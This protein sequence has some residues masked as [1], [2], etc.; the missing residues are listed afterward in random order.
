MWVALIGL[1]SL[2]SVGSK[3]EF[4]G[5]GLGVPIGEPA[6]AARRKIADLT[7]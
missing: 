2:L 6:E 5:T 1:I 4:W 7:D 3:A